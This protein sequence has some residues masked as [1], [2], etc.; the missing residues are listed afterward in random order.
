MQNFWNKHKTKIIIIAVVA[1]L[2]LAAAYYMKK[3]QPIKDGSGNEY[4]LT[5]E[6]KTKYGS[7]TE[8]L[9]KMK[10]RILSIP[11]WKAQVLT[12]DKVDEAKLLQQAIYAL[13][14]LDKVIELMPK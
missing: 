12:G 3:K 10:E 14:S 4:Q 7:T 5:T 8:A 6:G 1:L 13:V 11:E 9:E 2:L